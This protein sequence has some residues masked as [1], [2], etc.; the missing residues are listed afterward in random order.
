MNG[1]AVGLSM[2]CTL[3]R[4]VSLCFDVVE[5]LMESKIRRKASK[6]SVRLYEKALASSQAAGSFYEWRIVMEWQ[7]WT[8]TTIALGAAVP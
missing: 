5:V 6:E 7:K 1:R 3:L 8:R 4:T 2:P